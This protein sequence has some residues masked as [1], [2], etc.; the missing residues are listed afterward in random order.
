MANWDSLNNQGYQC[1][2]DMWVRTHTIVASY[3]NDVNILL[4]DHFLNLK[5]EYFKTE[6]LSFSPSLKQRFLCIDHSSHDSY[7]KTN[8]IVPFCRCIHAFL[9]ID[10]NLWILV[11]IEFM[12]KV[13]GTHSLSDASPLRIIVWL[14]PKPKRGSCQNCAMYKSTE[15]S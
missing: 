6:L 1:K 5:L 7:L 2:G 13:S 12:I 9:L 10:T 3:G 8:M 15:N 11:S 4:F 14:I